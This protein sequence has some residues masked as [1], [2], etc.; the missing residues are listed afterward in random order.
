M[1]FLSSVSESKII[2]DGEFLPATLLAPVKPHL[3]TGETGE[4]LLKNLTERSD[5]PADLSWY[6]VTLFSLHL[7][8]S[9]QVK[10]CR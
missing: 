2:T 1:Y 7:L 9:L 4:I 8:L 5:T 3:S 10:L 6:N